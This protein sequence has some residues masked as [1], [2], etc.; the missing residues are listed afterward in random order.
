MPRQSVQDIKSSLFFNGSGGITVPSSGT[1]SVIGNAS[2]TNY[3]WGVRAK[4]SPKNASATAVFAKAS[5]KYPLQFRIEANGRV[6]AAIYDGSANPVAQSPSTYADLQWHTLVGVRAGSSLK[7]YVDGALVASTTATI[8]D[9]SEASNIVI[10]GNTTFGNVSN[11]F[12]TLNALTADEVLRHH[13]TGVLPYPC[14]VDLPLDE[15]AGAVAYDRSGNS[16]NASIAS[17]IWSSDVPSKKRSVVGGNMLYNGDFEYAPPFTAATTTQF[18]EIDG[19]AAGRALAGNYLF[20]WSL[21][22]LTGTGSA[23]FDNGAMKLSTTAINSSVYVRQVGNTL[24][25]PFVIRC[26]PNTTY[27]ITARVKTNY[28]SG[29]STTGARLEVKGLSSSYSDTATYVVCNYI[30]TTTD[31]TQYSLTFTTGSSVIYLDPMMVVNG[32]GG[33][34]TLIMDAWFDGIIVTPSIPILRTLANDIKTSLEPTSSSFNI[35]APNSASNIFTANA[36]YTH[37]FAINARGGKR[38]DFVNVLYKKAVDNTD[39]IQIY[40]QNYASGL[41]RITV[42]DRKGYSELRSATFDS[43]RGYEWHTVVV[44]YDGANQLVNISID[45]VSL[46]VS[47]SMNWA[48]VI[49][50]STSSV[51][52]GSTSGTEYSNIKIARNIRFSRLLSDAEVSALHAGNNIT[53]SVDFDYKFD[54]GAGTT[55]YDGSGNGNHATIT[56]GTYT[57]DTPSKRR[58]IVGSNLVGNGDFEYAPPTSVPHTTMSRWVDG[59]AAGSTSNTNFGVYII[60]AAGISA[61]FD[62]SIKASGKNSLKVSAPANK[63]LEAY[64]GYTGYGT[65]KNYIPILPSTSYTLKFKMKTNYVSGDSNGARVIVYIANGAF[66]AIT[67]QNSTLVKTTTDWTSYTVTFT[68]TSDARYARVCGAV[69]TDVGAATLVMDA[70][71]DDIELRPTTLVPRGIA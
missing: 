47:G 50:N 17:G 39:G 45:G 9:A 4:L 57:I 8:G 56:A 49:S 2:N 12:V 37:F 53:G 64:V 55:A 40:L 43:L 31:W 32:T 60:G 22:A 42:Q 1:I 36:G 20:G 14:V 18:R 46:A 65:T 24:F 10:G 66:G 26:Q 61:Q 41:A 30:S 11:A 62:S 33:A 5:T 13:R 21:S 54:E 69:A 34:A 67:S 58:G 7:L 29:A 16:N 68:T 27:T 44:R 70:W 63:W 28:V 38:T 59:T 23:R 51:Y 6:R 15:G 3:S 35:I 48:N 25:R 19:T 52:V 71:F